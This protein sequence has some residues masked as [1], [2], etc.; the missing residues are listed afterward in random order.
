[1]AY[2]KAK[3]DAI[4]TAHEKVPLHL[5]NAVTNLDKE[6]NYGKGYVYAHDS[7]NKITN[8]KFPT[9]IGNEKNIKEVLKNIETIKKNNN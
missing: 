6:L 4:K 3:I 8:M 9:S 2:E 5:R 7:K 1:M